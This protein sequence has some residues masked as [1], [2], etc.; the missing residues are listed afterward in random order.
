MVSKNQIVMFPIYLHIN[1]NF[2]VILYVKIKK[3]QYKSKQICQNYLNIPGYSCEDI[4][5]FISVA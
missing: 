2:L 1:H 3:I 4:N 5:T